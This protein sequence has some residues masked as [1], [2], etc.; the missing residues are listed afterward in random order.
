MIRALRIGRSLWQNAY[1]AV[2]AVLTSLARLDPLPEDRYGGGR[3]DRS[4]NGSPHVLVIDDDVSTLE[5][6]QAVLE[7][8]GYR[9]TLLTTPDLAPEA[10]S[11]LDPSLIL[12]DLR[13]RHETDGVGLLER[14]KGDP[15]TRPIPVLVCSADHQLLDDLYDRLAA[16][17]CGVLPKP[18]GL[19]AL[20][21]AIRACVGQSSAVGVPAEYQIPAGSSPP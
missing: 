2:A 16:W 4:A 12:L 15:A 1:P 19:A 21:A 18:F 3:V 14:L 11:T 20:L 10:V 17:D 5:L 6:Y 7:E 13:F 8:E 9:L